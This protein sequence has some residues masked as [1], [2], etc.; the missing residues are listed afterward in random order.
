MRLT[1]RE[2]ARETPP[3]VNPGPL[4]F[5]DPLPWRVGVL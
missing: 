1:S 5:V 3:S 4:R 2:T